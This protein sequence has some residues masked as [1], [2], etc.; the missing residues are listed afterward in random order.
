M[1]IRA[2]KRIFG[3]PI[4]VLSLLI[5]GSLQA[6]TSSATLSG[7]VTD[8]S[9]AV[10][11]NAKISIKS[12]GSGEIT[13]TET[14]RA[15]QYTLP[16]LTPGDYEVAISAEQFSAK[17]LK[18]TLPAGTTQSLNTVLAAIQGQAQTPAGTLPNAP[19]SSKAEPSL[20]DLGFP[21]EQTQANS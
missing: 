18:T 8:A 9:G 17:V 12:L 21:P 2:A 5:S 15:G 4:V 6:Q 10:V 19:S 7:V 14:D 1:K 13:T 3:V 16:N 11:P 20:Q